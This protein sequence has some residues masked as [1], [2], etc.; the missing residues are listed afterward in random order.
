MLG[1][2]GNFLKEVVA[3]ANAQFLVHQSR[4]ATRGSERCTSS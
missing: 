4:A 1:E 2:A 3:N